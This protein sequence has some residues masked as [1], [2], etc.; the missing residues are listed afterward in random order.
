MD[1]PTVTHVFH[2][3]IRSGLFSTVVRY[4][5]R[6]AGA[7]KAK[8]S[9]ASFLGEPD[10]EDMLAVC[11]YVTTQLQDAPIELFMIGYSYGACVAAN[12]LAQLP[13]VVGVRFQAPS[14]VFIPSTAA[15]IHKFHHRMCRC[16]CGASPCPSVMDVDARAQC[17]LNSLVNP[18]SLNT[19]PAEACWAIHWHLPVSADRLRFPCWLLALIAS[20]GWLRWYRVPIGRG[21]QLGPQEPP[22]LGTAV[23]QCHPQAADP[24]HSRQVWCPQHTAHLCSRGRSGC[25]DNVT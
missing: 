16:C 3:A 13:Q 21:S 24:R 9:K 10:V 19:F 25:L 11:Q 17:S 4:N 7:S 22:P 1:D 23:R 12:S 5:M 18:A 15:R 20:G 14:N 2:A 8:W 6:G